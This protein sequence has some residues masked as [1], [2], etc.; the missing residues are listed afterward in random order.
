MAKANPIKAA[1]AD[2]PTS[3][4]GPAKSK[5]SAEPKAAETGAVQKFTV[6]H[7]RP[8]D[9]AAGGLRTYVQY[10]DLGIAEATDGMVLAHVLRFTELCD[11]A[12]VSKDH[13]HDVR[14][15][16]NYVLKGWITSEF[17]GHGIHTMKAGDAWLQPPRIRHKVLD[18]SADCELLEVVMPAN[19][20][21][22]EL[23]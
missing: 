13:L 6:S 21:T 5:R 14:F 22:V 4:P 8:E 2:R 15:Q 18:Y 23:E 20:A 7:F 17:E 11:P 10:R 19:F 12:V 1:T 16:M 9:F 3:R